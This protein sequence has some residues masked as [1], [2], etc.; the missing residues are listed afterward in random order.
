ME[1]TN[2]W[3]DPEYIEEDSKVVAKSS[4]KLFTLSALVQAYSWSLLGEA[5][6]ISN[7]N[8]EMFRKVAER[9]AF[10]SWFWQHISHLFGSLWVPPDPDRPGS[11]LAGPKRLEYLDAR[12]HERNIAFQASFLQA[13]GRLGFALGEIYNFTPSQSVEAK[14]ERLA[15]QD[16]KAYAGADPEGRDL[17]AWQPRYTQAFMKPHVERST[18]EVDGWVFDHGSETL[19]AGEKLLLSLLDLD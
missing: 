12:R 7:P 1:P 15:A 11:A 17:N 4:S 6:P 5:D 14:L 19:R 13:I 2:G 3:M 10:V 9:H 16:W 18:G 8:A